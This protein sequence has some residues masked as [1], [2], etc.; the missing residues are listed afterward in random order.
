VRARNLSP[1]SRPE[2]VGNRRNRG[3]FTRGA[4]FHARFAT[5]IG[6]RSQNQVFTNPQRSGLLPSHS[7]RATI[8]TRFGVVAAFWADFFLKD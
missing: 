5:V 6:A 3:N 1:D 7:I 4:A 8:R 2:T